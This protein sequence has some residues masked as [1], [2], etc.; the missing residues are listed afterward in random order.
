MT[1]CCC[2]NNCV[3]VGTIIYSHIVQP[4][5]MKADGR[6]LSRCAYAKL[7]RF[8]FE[9]QLM[10]S[11][12]DWENNM[13]GMFAE[14][15]GK[16]KFR[17][18]DLRGQFLRGLDDGRSIDAGRILGSEQKGTIIAYDTQV[19]GV[20][21]SSTVSDTVSDSQKDIGVDVPNASEYENV[22]IIGGAHTAVEVIPGTA[23]NLGCSGVVR[24]KNIAVIAQ[25]KY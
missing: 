22:R 9:N 17:I 19:D 10:L 5:Y 16:S 18:P 2:K 23:G 8:A 1:E 4:G 12:A 15:D 21:S 7:F 14:G 11:E 24:P 6:L 25:I 20:W 3:N 13:Q